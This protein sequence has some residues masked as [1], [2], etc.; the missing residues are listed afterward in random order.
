MSSSAA[1]KNEVTETPK[2]KF[3]GYQPNAGRKKGSLNKRTKMVQAIATNALKPGKTP[4]DIMLKNMRFYDEK[5]QAMMTILETKIAA[6]NKKF[7]PTEVLALLQEMSQYRMNAQKCATDA[8]PFIHP[9]LT[10]IAFKD[11]TANTMKA[12][13]E[14]EQSAQE[15]AEYY[16]NLRLRPTQ[17]SPLIIDNDTGEQ[18][19]ETAAEEEFSYDD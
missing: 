12:K 3:G 2:R 19:H 15:L 5:A 11:E 4:L 1:K 6:G 7:V 8:A 10:S 17:V 18:V 16:N 9:K 14:T 13:P